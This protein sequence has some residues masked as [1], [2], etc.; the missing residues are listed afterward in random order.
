M[1]EII[2]SMTTKP[3]CVDVNQGW[4]DRNYALEMAH[5]LLKRGN[6]LEQADAQISEG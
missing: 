1:V 4:T 3:L 2:R 6:I 5:W